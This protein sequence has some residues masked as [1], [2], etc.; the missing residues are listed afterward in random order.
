MH[1]LQ[2]ASEAPTQLTSLKS[3][4]RVAIVHDWIFTRRGGEKVLERLLN[5]FPHADLFILFGD[6]ESILRTKGIHRVKKSFLHKLPGV[7]RY[8]K[9]LLPLFPLAT[10]SHDLTGYDLVISSSSCAAKGVVP[11]PN[12]LHISYVHSPMRYAWD[13]ERTYFRKTPQ[14]SRPIA[15]L[16]GL[17]LSFLRMWDVTSSARVDLFLSNSMFVQRR[18]ELYYGRQAEVLHPPVHLAPYLAIATR[19]IQRQNTV[20]LFGTWTP[21]KQL[22]VALEILL[23]KGFRV[24]AAGHGER[25]E[26]ARAQHSETNNGRAMT[27]PS[28]SFVYS[29]SDAELCQLYEQA[30]VLVYPGVED[31]GIIAV[32]AMASGLWVVGPCVGGTAE[33]IRPGLTGFHFTPRKWD[34]MAEAVAQALKQEPPTQSDEWGEHI[35]SFSE[36]RFDQ[37]FIE[38]VEKLRSKR[39]GQASLQTATTG[40]GT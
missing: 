1:V 19:R 40:S 2:S 18:I 28:V 10:E 9:F 23:Q 32:E 8:Y 13:M 31:F 24:I 16:R 30:H 39:N 37:A 6:P 4:G 11:P 21:Y 29:P 7:E 38:A 34:Q 17:F 27:T 12:A 35:R 25:F 36:E 22:E 20:L 26:A 15:L 33:T 14:L 3:Y 5:Q